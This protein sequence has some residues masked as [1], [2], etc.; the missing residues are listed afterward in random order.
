LA[1]IDAEHFGLR[2]KR[3]P[4]AAA[5]TVRFLPLDD[6]GAT[7]QPSRFG[8]SGN[9][10]ATAQRAMAKILGQFTMHCFCLPNQQQLEKAFPPFITDR[11]RD[12]L[13]LRKGGPYWWPIRP[14]ETI[15]KIFCLSL[16]QETAG[17]D[18]GRCLRLENHPWLRQRDTS[19]SSPYFPPRAYYIPFTHGNGS[20]APAAAD[21]GEFPFRFGN[22]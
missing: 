4:A 1:Q 20:R 7:L 16:K 2:K 9:R 18:F 3:F 15:S 8:I 12:S 22:N 10:N 19:S 5:V 21:R 14:E 13:Q 6:G 17:F 11:E